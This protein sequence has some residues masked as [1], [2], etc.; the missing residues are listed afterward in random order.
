[1][2]AP[3]EARIGTFAEPPSP[4]TP[5]LRSDIAYRRAQGH[6]WD[7]IGVVFHYHSDA[8]RR[9]AEGD[10][11]YAAAQEKAR[12][13]AA[14]EGEADGL[15]RLR[16]LAD[17]ADDGRAL[18]AAEVLVKY[19][20]ERRRDDT[21]LAV[22]RLR[23]DA[24]QARA[25]ARPAQAGAAREEPAGRHLALRTPSTMSATTALKTSCMSWR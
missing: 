21:R 12:A 14:W 18:A 2:V 22:E 13:E 19:A 1:M 15:C 3:A 25:A 24:Q 8:L 9:A 4:L 10:P 17:G 5:E 6:S 11:E 7:A 16:L 23:A 20:R